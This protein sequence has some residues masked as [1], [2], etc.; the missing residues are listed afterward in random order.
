MNACLTAKYY[1]EFVDQ[2]DTLE[3]VHQLV[4]ENNPGEG[5]A[6]SIGVAATLEQWYYTKAKYRSSIENLE[7]FHRLGW[8]SDADLAEAKAETANGEYYKEYF[9]KKR[10]WDGFAWINYQYKL[11]KEKGYFKGDCSTATTV[12]MARNG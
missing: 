7:E 9:G 12:Q 6:A 2:I 10:R 3:F 8:N 11:F 4:R 5:M 1:R